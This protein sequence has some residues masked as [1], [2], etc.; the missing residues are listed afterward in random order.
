[1][2]KTGGRGCGTSSTPH[3]HQQLFLTSKSTFF[4]F[5]VVDITFYFTFSCCDGPVDLCKGYFLSWSAAF[6]FL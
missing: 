1:M 3:L 6:M 5:V 4:F 2:E